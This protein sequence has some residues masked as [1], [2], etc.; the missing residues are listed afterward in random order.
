MG[1]NKLIRAAVI[2]DGINER[3]YNIGCLD[4][5]IEINHEFKICKR[6]DYNNNLSSHGT[7]CAAIIK[8]YA[9]DVR[10]GSIKILNDVR[11][12]AERYQ[13]I[14]AIDWCIQNGVKLVNLS[15][16]TIDFRDFDEI[17]YCVNMAA[18]NGLIIISACN[19]KNTYTVPSCLTNVIGVRC[20]KTYID[21]QYKFIPY[22]FDGID[23]EASGR[24]L[25]ADIYG[26][27]MYTRPFNSFAAPFVTAMVH[28]ILSGNPD[29]LLEEIKEEL[30]RNAT[31][32]NN[33]I[34][35][36]Y[37]CMNTDWFDESMEFDESIGCFYRSVCYSVRENRKLWNP[38]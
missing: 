28:K 25:L 12:R 15:L 34:Y 16:G 26:K 8:K 6:K 21:A 5:N 38:E 31:D 11:K 18:E 4:F 30:H 22:S 23:V 1:E 24:H 35:N 9:P 29:A 20:R 27:C 10:L 37:I 19:N 33:N 7:T 32:L 14:T 36:P 2:D 3:L 13:L 17:R